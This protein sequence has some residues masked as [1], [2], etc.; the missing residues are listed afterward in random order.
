MNFA[1]GLELGFLLGALYVGFALPWLD[2][3]FRS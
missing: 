3:K 2:K 1:Q